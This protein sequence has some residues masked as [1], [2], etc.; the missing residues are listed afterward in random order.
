MPE[1]KN[2]L[3]AMVDRQASDLHLLVGSPAFLRIDGVLKPM[4][5]EPVLLAE[6][7]KDLIFPLLS[8]SQKDVF[9]VNKELDMSVEL[10]SFGRFRVN[11]YFQK[12]TMAAALRLISNKIRT[13]QEL[14]LPKI[15]YQLTELRQGLILVTGPTGHGKSTTLAAI[16]EQINQSR[17]GH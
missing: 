5:G 17:A 10:G 4:E 16:I 1:I 7:I 11:T 3:K 8:P 2:L 9:L 13:I 12:G 15:C 14:K 6:T